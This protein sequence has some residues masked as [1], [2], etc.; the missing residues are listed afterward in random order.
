MKS[1]KTN[2]SL[3]LK[4]VTL[5]LAL[6]VGSCVNNPTKTRAQ[7]A[8]ASD[9]EKYIKIALLLDTSNSMDGLIEQAKSQLWQLVNELAKAECEG[10]APTLQIALY[11]Y[12]NDR[13]PA[14]EGYIHQVTPLT[15]DLDQ[16]SE[17]LFK[18][19]TNGGSEFCGQAIQTAIDQQDWSQ[20]ADDLQILFIAG[21]EPFTQG[22]VDYKTPCTNAREKN[23]I[24]NT[25]H[26]GS[27]DEGIRGMWKDGADRGGGQYMCIEQDRKTVYIASPYDD[28]IMLLNKQLNKTY[29]GYGS[30]GEAKKTA[31]MQQDSNAA[32]YSQA[33]SVK[34]AISK[35]SHF[36]KNSKWDLVDASKQEKFKLEEIDDKQLPKEM[37][38]KT[39]AEKE[40]YIADKAKERDQ[41]KKQIQELNKKRLQ[42]IA[43]KQKEAGN[44]EMLDKAMI[45]AIKEQAAFKSFSFN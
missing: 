22:R 25:I 35:S 44:D 27:F 39:L 11:E 23:I 18:L 12:G 38:G 24:V 4:S 7:N 31:Q 3:H 2:W 9:S 10:T 20:S 5:L 14:S 34:R 40:K 29:I 1:S 37:Q 13:L 42:F 45:K 32:S 19:T 30:L 17:D 33:N 28:Q 43:E 16:I 36:Y 21:N 8:A 41:I 6:L 26:C 15:D